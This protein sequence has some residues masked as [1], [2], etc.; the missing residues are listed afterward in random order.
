MT[1]DER[2]ALWDIIKRLYRTMVRA[3]ADKAAVLQILREE[4]NE[5]QSDVLGRLEDF[6]SEPFYQRVLHDCEKNI[7]ATEA[8]IRQ[9]ATDQELVEQLAQMPVSKLVN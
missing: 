9:A 3:E 5:S 1:Q 6:H 8:A 2:I 7:L 4:L